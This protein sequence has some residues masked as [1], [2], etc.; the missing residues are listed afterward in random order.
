MFHKLFL[1]AFA[2][3]AGT[4]AIGAMAASP[5]SVRIQLVDQRGLPVRDAVVDLTPDGG[6]SGPVSIPGRAAMAQK[7]LQFVPGT[8]VVAKGDN[9]AFPNLDRVRHHV[10]SFSKAAKFEIELYGREQTRSQR[11]PVAGAVS[12][13]C[14]IHDGMR[15]YI[16][17]VDTPFAGKTDHNGFVT[18][19][20]I[21]TGG[22]MIS[23]WHPRMK[24]SDNTSFKA[25]TI[26]GGAQARRLSV[27]M[28]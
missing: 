11:F 7:N 18:L 14:N 4:A 6:W 27:Q 26:V 28:R 17:V 5:A 21:P 20:G 19:D 1:A 2:L 25:M 22:A 8:L 12:L 9:V 16:K 23:A 13:G 10:Y 24:S 3:A 15:G